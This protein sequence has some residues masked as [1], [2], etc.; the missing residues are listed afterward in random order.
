V[1]VAGGFP[2][3]KVAFCEFGWNDG[4]HRFRTQMAMSNGPRVKRALAPGWSILQVGFFDKN[5]VRCSFQTGTCKT[6]LSAS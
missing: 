6:S 4:D 1:Q 2:G 3:S 5:I